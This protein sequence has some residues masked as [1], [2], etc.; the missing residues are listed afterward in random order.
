MKKTLTIVIVC[1][2]LA[3]LSVGCS[4]EN[5]DGKLN[6]FVER[7][8]GNNEKVLVDYDDITNNQWFTGSTEVISISNASVSQKAC[9]VRVNNN[10]YYI[11][12]SIVGGSGNIAAGY[13]STHMMT[14]SGA[15]ITTIQ[16]RT[17]NS[18]ENL[19]LHDNGDVKV[20][21][22]MAAYAEEGAQSLMFHHLTGA[23]AFSIK[24]TTAN[25]VTLNSIKLSSSDNRMWSNAVYNV[26]TGAVSRLTAGSDRSQSDTYNVKKA[27]GT[28]YYTLA[29]NGGEVFVILPVPVCGSSVTLTVN[30]TVTGAVDKTAFSVTLGDGVSANTIYQLNTIQLTKVL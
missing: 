20:R 25:E 16:L 24:N 10:N 26:S 1:S 3:F 29:A 19:Y 11:D 17:S 5:T 21:F 15:N 22:P 6:I 4:K 18:S 7:L 13:P 30:L 2:A 23:I 9:T 14:G 8:G 28:S 27:N 12:Y